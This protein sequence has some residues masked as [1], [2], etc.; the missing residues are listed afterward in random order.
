MMRIHGRAAVSFLAVS[1]WIVG[2]IGNFADSAPELSEAQDNVT[3][4]D[5]YSILRPGNRFAA[6]V[7]DEYVDEIQ[8]LLAQRCA[9]CHACTNGPCQLNMTSY[10]ALLR[11]V[12]ST[13]PYNFGLFDKRPTRVAD[14]RP[15][16]FWRS[17]G[18]RSVLP[19]AGV[20]PEKS[21]FY[22]SLEQGEKN[23]SSSDPAAGALAESVVRPMAKAH[24]AGDYVCPATA[25]EYERIKAKHKLPGMPWA[26]PNDAQVHGALESWVLAGAN[27][28]SAAA[29]K[30]IS[31]PQ[32]TAHTLVDPAEIVARWEAFLDGDDLRSQLVGRYIYEHAYSVNIHFSENPGEFY[33]IVRSRTAAPAAIDAI[34]SDM[35]QDD[36]KVS[37][38]HYRLEKIDRVIEGKTHVPWVRSLRDLEHMREQFLGTSWSVQKLPGY[39]SKNPF[40][41]FDAIPAEARSRFMLENSQMIYAAFARGPICLIAAASYAVDEYFWIL[42]LDPASDPTVREP[43]LGLGSY[44][45]FFT[46]DGGLFSGVPVVGDSYGVNT[47]RAAF[48]KT[49]R[50]LKPEGL[51]ID[52]VWKGDGVYDNAWLTVHRHQFSVDVHPTTARPITGLPK[53][54]WFMSY[55]NFERMYYNAVTQ[56]KYWGSLVHQNDSFNWQIYTRTEA[57]DMWA[58]LFPSD[59]YRDELRTHYTSG[60]GKVYYKLYT[61]FIKG[62]PSASPEYSN[63]D[64][65][66]RALLTQMSSVVGPEDR[67]NNW[68]NTSLPSGIPSSVGSTD[69]FEAGL[70]TLTGKVYGFSRY[71]PNAV[72]VRLGGEHLYTLLAVREHNDDRIPGLEKTARVPERDY[73]V[74]IPGFAAYEAHMFVDLSYEQ[75]ADFLRALSDVNDQ[76]SWNAFSRR[77]KVGRNSPQFWSF[78]DFMHDWQEEHMP[79]RAGLMELRMY[80]MD[81]TPF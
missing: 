52:D 46:K 23:T 17:E 57:E 27:G 24:E 19:G 72:H 59:A 80:D 74:A 5:A 7:G 70:R 78:V 8:P 56:Y 2:C 50:K 1:L 76:A 15:L 42:F 21:V 75:A 47:Y 12:S 13:N 25:S 9:V 68:P 61:D 66:A 11:G 32:R 6:P 53:S 10:A 33:R 41:T 26:L 67:L 54:V 31:S 39:G 28:P 63:E 35:P 62:R 77:F 65:L 48:E 18:F 45:D 3:A 29:Q 40:E 58:S 51:G 64:Q 4:A 43:K 81:E 30:A 60:V 38:V 37:R 55:A 79:V 14:N 49:L 34:F 16:S 44:K 36:P 69:D 73:M 20:A 71:L 22:L